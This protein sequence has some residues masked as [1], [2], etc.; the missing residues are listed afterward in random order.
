MITNHPI[1]GGLPA[2]GGEAADQVNLVKDND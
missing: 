1:E 2:W